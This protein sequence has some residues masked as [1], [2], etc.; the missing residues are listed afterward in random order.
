MQRRIWDLVRLHCF[1][2]VI[3]IRLVD[4]CFIAAVKVCQN[5]AVG[6]VEKSLRQAFRE[7]LQLTQLARTGSEVSSPSMLRKRAG[8]ERADLLALG[9]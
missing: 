7:H 3:H 9:P 4:G 8:G 6:V 5:L 2:V 1:S